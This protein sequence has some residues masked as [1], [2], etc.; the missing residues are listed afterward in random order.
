[1]DYSKFYDMYYNIW[2]VF[3]TVELWIKGAEVKTKEEVHIVTQMIVHIILFLNIKYEN[4]SRIEEVMKKLISENKIKHINSCYSQE[5]IVNFLKEMWKM[6]YELFE[7][8]NF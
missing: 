8:D 2:K 7:L 1:M 5:D 3:E 6:Y 4:K